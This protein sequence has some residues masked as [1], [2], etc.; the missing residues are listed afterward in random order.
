MYRCEEAENVMFLMSEGVLVVKLKWEEPVYGKLEV[1]L[2][3]GGESGYCDCTLL[4]FSQH[5]EY[6]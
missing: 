4:Y 2:S 1:L 6:L 3:S 5:L